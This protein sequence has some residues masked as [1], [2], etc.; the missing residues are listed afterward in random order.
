MFE[1]ATLSLIAVATLGACA[2]AE[3]IE[4][5]DLSNCKQVGF[6]GA[7]FT[8]CEFDA[9]T[10]EIRLFHTAPDGRPFAQFSR[11][12]ETVAAD[13]G[14][15][16]F[17]MNARMYHPDRSPVGLYIEDGETVRS[18]VR[19]DGPGN[20]QLLPNGVFWIE[21]GL[22]GVTETEAY[23]E[24]ELAPRHATQSGPLLV[25]DG[26][27]HPAFREA[28]DSLFIRNGVGVAEDGQTV[29]FA[30]SSEPVNFHHFARLFRDTLETP[31]ALFL[32][33]KVS[34]LYAPELGRHD[35]G[36]GMGPIV[37]VVRPFLPAPEGE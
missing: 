29:F 18:L 27:L 21:D 10:D 19:G 11:V 13:G 37:G 5:A 1:R 23:A 35:F 9:A 36:F 22:V 32:D 15:L 12:S 34:K 31:N 14:E 28:S 2:H 7:T 24:A 6:D 3:P 20:F 8:V 17:A 16:I 26:E 25:L 33:G 30:I 4:T